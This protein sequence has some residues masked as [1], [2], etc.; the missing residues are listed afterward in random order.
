MLGPPRALLDLGIRCLSGRRYGLLA[1]TPSSVFVSTWNLGRMVVGTWKLKLHAL[2][3]VIVFLL[4]ARSGKLLLGIE[5]NKKT[6]LHIPLTSFAPVHSCRTSWIF[7][8]EPCGYTPLFG[9]PT[10]STKPLYLLSPSAAGPPDVRLSRTF[11][12]FLN[13][14]LLRGLGHTGPLVS[15]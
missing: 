8:V 12:R 13:Y 15:L 6:I 14:S 10:P 3:A 4:I 7:L 9:T 5:Q 2:A 11:T 1:G